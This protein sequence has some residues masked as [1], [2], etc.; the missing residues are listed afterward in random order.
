MAPMV[1]LLIRALVLLAAASEVLFRTGRAPHGAYYAGGAAAAM[2]LSL[3]LVGREAASEPGRRKF[4]ERI[5][6]RMK[7]A[8][9][10]QSSSVG[11]EKIAVRSGLASRSGT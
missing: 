4:G 3:T 2:V 9:A 11:Q 1:G 6:S 5:A 10:T 8:M 7:S